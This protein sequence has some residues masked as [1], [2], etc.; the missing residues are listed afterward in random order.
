[1][2]LGAL[3]RLGYDIPFGR[4]VVL[5][6]PLAQVGL[7]V[8]WSLLQLLLRPHDCARLPSLH[9]PP[10]T[11]RGVELA[12]LAAVAATVVLWAALSSVQQHG[13]SGCLGGAIAGH[14]GLIRLHLKA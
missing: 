8:V 9:M 14:H 6:L 7:L 2:A 11:L 3:Q 1:M 10:G 12:I 4:W 5:A 13:Q